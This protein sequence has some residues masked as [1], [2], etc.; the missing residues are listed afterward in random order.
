M[1]NSD[2]QVIGFDSALDEALSVFRNL[3]CLAH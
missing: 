3:T 1:A 2:R